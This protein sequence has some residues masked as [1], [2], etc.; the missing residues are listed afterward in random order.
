MHVIQA[1]ITQE[2]V[3]EGDMIDVLLYLNH[4]TGKYFRELDSKRVESMLLKQ[5]NPVDRIIE[6]GNPRALDPPEFEGASPPFTWT[7]VQG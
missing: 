3:G 5:Q 6:S 7:D 4:T 1:V 2:D